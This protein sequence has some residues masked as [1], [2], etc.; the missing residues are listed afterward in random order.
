MLE[1]LEQGKVDIVIATHRLLHAHARFKDL[2]LLIIDEEHRFGVRDKE[3]LQALRAERAR[4]HAHRDADP[5][6]AQ[7]GAWAA[8]ATCR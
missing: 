5:A 6:H 2:G 3:R 1:G 7:H 4:A 8:C